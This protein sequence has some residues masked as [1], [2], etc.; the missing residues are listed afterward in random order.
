M[1]HMLIHHLGCPPSESRAP[2]S[3]NSVLELSAGEGA[4]ES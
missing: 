1:L 2:S 4:C 3:D